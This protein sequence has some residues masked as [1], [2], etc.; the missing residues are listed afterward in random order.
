MKRSRTEFA[1]QV[2]RRVAPGCVAVL[3]AAAAMLCIGRAGR[4]GAASDGGFERQGLLGADPAKTW[5]AAESAVAAETSRVKAGGAAMRWHIAVDHFGGEAKYPIG[6]PRVSRAL[7]GTERDWSG[8]DFLEFWIYSETS[9]EK[10]PSAPLALLVRVEA[11]E[12]SW[13]RPLTE[14]KKGEWVRFVVPV[15]DLPRPEAVQQVMFS[16]SDSNYRHQD[17]VTFTIADLALVRYAAPTLLDFAPEQGVMFADAA[18]VAVRFRVTGLG[19]GETAETLCELRRDGAVVSRAAA[20]AGRG[21]HRLVLPLG[22]K[23][24]AP[25]AY[26]VVAR[27]GTGPPQRAAVRLV[28]SPW[29]ERSGKP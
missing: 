22:E 17:Q 29:T 24:P 16:I 4:A 8:W 3:I 14:L 2:R 12:G 1:R 5:S 7:R 6:W 21:A 19:P 15:A 13:S 25:G 18:G 27:I 28:Q 20:A 9:R 11:G 10:L 26:E 23:R